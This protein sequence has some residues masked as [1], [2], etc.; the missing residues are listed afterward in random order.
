MAL[1]RKMDL[2]LFGEEEKPEEQVEQPE[3]ETEEVENQEEV[4]EETPEET[5]EEKL[6]EEEAK[7]K[8]EPKQDS[9][10]LAKYLAE[11]KKRQEYEKVLA[12][13]AAEKEKMQLVQQLI[14]RGWP[15]YEAAIQAEEKI[16]QKQESEQLKSKLL[17]LDIKEL[18]GSDPFYADAYSF[19]D[20]IKAKMRELGVSAEE[21]YML[22]RGRVRTREIQLENEQRA[23]ARRK[24]T[25]PKRIDTAPPTPPKSPY[26][27]D[28]DDK[29]ALA[30]LQEVQPDAGWT[31]EKYW[32]LM[33]T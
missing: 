31:V 14:E 33:K 10:P 26:K 19:K 9:V 17:D 5:Q 32:K 15:E 24:E 11:K 2:Q 7:S 29:K 6:P 30:K 1:K 28:D 12:Q 3:V 23:A 8:P 18:A 25:A 4:L 16:K 21:A 13:Q 20:D 22:L 27:L